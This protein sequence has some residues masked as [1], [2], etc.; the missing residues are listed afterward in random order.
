MA[1]LFTPLL[2]L[3]GLYVGRASVVCSFHISMIFHQISPK[4][5]YSHRINVSLF[6]AVK[7]IAKPVATRMKTAAAKR[8]WL[9][10]RFVSLGQWSHYVA[11]RINVFAAGYVT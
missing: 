8:P 4:S 5:S 1:T 9:S 11:T 10:R 6:R 7:V 3:S 2:K